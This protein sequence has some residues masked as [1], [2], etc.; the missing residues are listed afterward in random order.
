[1]DQCQTVVDKLVGHAKANGS[2]DDYRLALEVLLP[3]SSVYAFLEGR[4]QRP[5]LTYTRL[6]ELTEVEEK[7]R[8]NKEIGERRTRLGA[9]IGQVTSDVTREVYRGSRLED[10]YQNVIDWT[11]DDDQRRE[12]EEKLLKRAYD[13]LMVLPSG[14]KADKRAQ[15]IKL[16]HDMVIIKHPS[17]LAWRLELE[18]TDMEELSHWDFGVL[19]EYVDLFPDLGL[20][21]VIKAFLGEEVVHNP[22]TDNEH[23]SNGENLTKRVPLSA[24]DRLLLMTVCT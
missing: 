18:W 11:N 23:D 24:D 22:K 10:L 14:E 21:R 6:A 1:M 5:A 3:T 4:I 15:V 8:I 19:R 20:A 16:A 17:Q 12:Y 2:R 7:E 9:K 13:N